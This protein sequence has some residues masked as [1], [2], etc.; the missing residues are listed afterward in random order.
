MRCYLERIGLDCFGSVLTAAV[1]VFDSQLS[2]QMV[3]RF[4]L[5]AKRV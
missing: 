3:I 2:C 1:M 4:Y 5:P